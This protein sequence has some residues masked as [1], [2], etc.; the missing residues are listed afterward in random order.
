M[1]GLKSLVVT[2]KV[3]EVEYPGMPGLVV[4]IAAISRET[5]KKL[6]E[7]S[8]ITKYDSKLRMPV[9]E[10]DEDKFIESFAAAAVK[11]WKG[12]KYKYLPEFMLVDL[13][14]IDPESELEYSQEDAVTLIKHSTVFDSWLNDQVFSLESFR[15]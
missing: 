11:G 4:Q 1:A 15:K 5:S 10:M 3:A 8:E 13:T 12:F 6:K 9:K 7:S 14:D 2:T